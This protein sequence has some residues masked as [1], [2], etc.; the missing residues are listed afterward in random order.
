MNYR[1]GI[2]IDTVSRGVRSFASGARAGFR[3]AGQNAT[4]AT[5]PVQRFTQAG[6]QASSV[7]SSFGR[8]AQHAGRGV[9]SFGKGVGQI[10]SLLGKFKSG[11]SNVVSSVFNLQNALI[12]AAALMTGGVFYKALIG[13]NAE[14]EN[15]QL[16]MA[17]VINAN[18]QFKNSTGQLLDSREN[19]NEAMKVSSTLVNQ[20]TRDAIKSAGSSQELIEIANVAINPTL[21]AGGSVQTVRELANQALSV[22]KILNIDT[23]QAARDIQQILSGNAGSEVLTFRGLR[24]FLGSAEE[25]NAL[26]APQRLAKLQDAMARFATPEAIAAQANSW[27]GLTSSIGDFWTL[28]TRTLGGPLFA[29]IKGGLQRIV[30]ALVDAEGNPTE[31][32]NNITARVTAIGEGIARGFDRSVKFGNQLATF[33]RTKLYPALQTYVLPV[34]RYFVKT[35][36]QGFEVVSGFIKQ[37]PE[38]VDKMIK[39][40]AVVLALTTAAA[41][42]TALGLGAIF[43]GLAWT[44]G[45]VFSIVTDVTDAFE[46]LG[47]IGSKSWRDIELSLLKSSQSMIDNPVFKALA[48]ATG[49]GSVLAH[50]GFIDQRIAMLEAQ[51]TPSTFGGTGFKGGGGWGGTDVGGVIVNQN[52]VTSDPTAAANASAR[53]LGGAVQKSIPGAGKTGTN[54]LQG[55]Y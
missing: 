54:I 22:A 42:F 46:T 11:V 29:K 10:P 5:S 28:T 26:T 41:G 1:L 24:S 43:V 35:F 25:F 51:D 7:Y 45:Q 13:S 3:S 20:F 36:Q 50:K 12:G 39:G 34:I 17:A 30:E 16:G 4:R 37:N 40:A 47:Q 8:T 31:L 9:A 44:I 19:F 49:T 21:A 18:L 15:Q 32:A 14:L 55:A 2:N 53:L 27:K 52:I 33:Y 23:P 48:V 38:F 6:R